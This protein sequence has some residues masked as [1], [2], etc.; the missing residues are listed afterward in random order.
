MDAEVAAAAGFSADFSAG[1]RIAGYQLEE[2]IGQGG[3]AVVFRA[4][5]ERL[6]RLVALKILSPALA[7]DESFR[8]RF[9]RE[10]RS[11]AAVDHPHIIPVF[12]AGESA[13][14]L[15]LA[16][17]YVP[18]G[19]A[20]TLVRRLGPLPA[21]RAAAIISAMAS[22]LDAAHA[23][24]LVH[25]DVK[26]ANMLVDSRPGEPDHVYLSDFGLTKGALTSAEL[27]GTGNFLGTLDY[28]APEQIEGG[29]VDAR[30]DE[31]A[32]ACAAFELLSAQPP[33]PR[34]KGMAVAYAQLSAAPPRLTSR[35]PDLP[36]PADDVL[37]R[38]LAK[39]PAHR[40]ASCGQF[41]AALR[42]ALRVAQYDPDYGWNPAPDHPPTEVA[43]I[44]ERDGRESR[45]TEDS[46]PQPS[47]QLQEPRQLQEPQ[48]PARGG[49]LRSRGV[50]ALAVV[51]ALVAG[52]A[53][54]AVIATS[55]PGKTREHL[56]DSQIIRPTGS[57]AGRS[58]RTGPS[59]SSSARPG[60]SLATPA[61]STSSR[62]SAGGSYPLIRTF[63][64]PG[65]GARQVSS[66]AFS[67][68]GA[69]LATGDM[70]GNAYLWSVGS[71]HK[72][73]VLRGSGGAK[74]LSVAVSPD[75]T[76][77]ATGDG[78]GTTYLWRTST[79]RL[80]TTISDTGDGAINSVAFSP[81]GKTIATGDKNGDAYLWDI[82]ATGQPATLAATLTD[83]SGAGVWALAFSPDGKTLATGDY[84]GNINLWNLTGSTSSPA[85]TFTVA[86][87]QYITAVA[88]SP[89]GK[90]LATG[91][92]NGTTYLW[93]VA[94][95][96]R[97]VVPEPG[98]VWGVAISKG[99][100]LAIGDSDG[101]TYL[102]NITSENQIATVT[103]PA[104]GSQGVGS[105]AFTGDGRTLA[106][107]DSNGSTYLWRIA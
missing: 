107:G 87:G 99:G 82:S 6:E 58:A 48:R 51:F 17:R 9:I 90:T 29:K 93:N 56:A 22:A 5:D 102:W 60:K 72:A 33:F 74:V 50:L 42:T 18:G 26:P 24:G 63:S 3:M 105:V 25:R 46:V 47:Q 67:G 41:A 11:A 55:N 100:T 68:D 80:I 21:A 64:D 78:N 86:G 13:G 52:G 79:G 75:G 8:Q 92:Y 69:T 85:N 53:A 19:D 49:R 106:T 76:L 103:D 10:S 23:T 73:G 32:L 20:G 96:A 88:F 83:P 35:R 39:E 104:T 30:T 31:Y 81:D 77:T 94:S 98:T 89:D 54:A 7:A 97:T 2:R 91:N 61:T 95:G 59:S 65:N 1:S 43:R 44:G 34:N 84:T 71:G 70:N 101:S 38:A 37:S 28:C 15:F 62:P 27:T 36:A 57:A 45:L 14:V 40:Y 66:V 4:R 12:E 16:M